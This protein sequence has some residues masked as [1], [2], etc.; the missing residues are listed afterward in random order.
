MLITIVLYTA[1][2]VA[3]VG[4]IRWGSSGLPSGDWTDLARAGVYSSAPFYHLMS[5]LGVALLASV[6]LLDAVISP[7]GTVGVYVGSSARDLYALAEG[8]QIGG[9]VSKVKG[10]TGSRGRRCSFR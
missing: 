2:E 3:F 5:V 10:D 1:L 9:K 7:L 4:G 6:L 8:E